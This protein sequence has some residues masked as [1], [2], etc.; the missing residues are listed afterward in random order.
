M[1]RG[2]SEGDG[3]A[4]WRWRGWRVRLT[5]QA[6]GA[7]NNGLERYPPLRPGRRGL[8]RELIESYQ[9][10]RLIAALT[11]VVHE[12]GVGDLTAARIIER[13]RMSR[14]TFYELFESK[15]ACEEAGCEEAHKH[16]FDPVKAAAG[17]PWPW[18]DRVSEA[19]GAFLDAVVEDP[20]LAELCLV[21]S[22][23]IPGGGE[24]CH[25]AGIEAMTDLIRGGREEG[26]RLAGGDAYQEPPPQTEEFVACAI[27]SVVAMRLKRGEVADL[28]GLRG[29]L[30]R[31]AASPFLGVEEA[32]RYGQGL[33]AA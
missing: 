31:M 11:E 32:T 13:A 29:E 24:S 30:V 23:A 27:V 16:L 3:V 28:P 2:G 8:P 14:K 6:L 1:G 10:E 15:G 26:R 21:H 22:V 12:R 25:R 9:R 17:A 18:L 20:L 33:E 5:E 19:V 4:G 7:G